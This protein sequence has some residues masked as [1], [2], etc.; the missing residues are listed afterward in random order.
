MKNKILIIFFALL[1]TGLLK[2][3]KPWTLQQCV[4]TALAN[5]RTVK[6]QA[7]A[8]KN[9]DIA[10]EQARKNLLPNLNA[11]ASQ[12]WNFGRSLSVDNTYKSS[13]SSQSSFSISSG[14]T[15]FDGMKM[16][17]SIDASKADMLAA[18][19]DLEKIKQDITMNVALGFMQILLNKELL[20]IAEVQLGLTRT[21]IEQRK[22]LVAAGKLAEGELLDLQAQEANEEMSRLQADNTLKLS[23][24]DLAQYLEI[25]NFEKM[26]VVAP[27][28]LSESEMQFLTADAV[29]QSAL[30]HRPEIKG[31]EYR[32][33]SSEY[34]VLIAK[35][36]YYPSLSLGANYG[37]GY[38]NLS[39]IPNNSFGQQLNDN[40]SA[41][42]GLNLR[43]PIFNKFEVR[44][45]VRSAELGVKSSK[46]SM[47]NA[48][49]ELK[50]SIQ[51]A[52]YNA[53][54]AKSRWDAAQKSEVASREAYR[55]TN[56][57]YE[58]GKATLYELY[59]AK[60]NLTQVL[61]EGAQAKYQ[62]FFRVKMLELL[63]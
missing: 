38:Y 40:M 59:Q 27:A 23:L 37:T 29:F 32:L 31:A 54:G 25:D 10:Y 8:K 52:Y 48:K 34:N 7:L 36:N 26:D 50:K 51:Q 1:I 12:N 14:L 43:I 45:G 58:G 53:L 21:K 2:A 13:N 11:S 4:D 28:A 35:G 30:T 9:K 33:K 3:Q 20:Q 15:L 47:D 56:Q 16:K 57:K 63:K 46:I 62:Y 6:Q 42:I 61:S 44:N 55:F 18:N 24:L 60:S 49:L 39:S 22:G 41:Q 19:A 5:N 17:Y